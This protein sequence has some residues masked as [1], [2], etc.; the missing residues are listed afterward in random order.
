MAVAKKVPAKKAVAAKKVP[1][2][3]AF[4]S[5]AWNTKYGVKKFKKKK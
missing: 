5:A 4:G 3:P 2:N 1:A